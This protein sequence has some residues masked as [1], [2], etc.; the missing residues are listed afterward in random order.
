[1][2]ATVIA[3]NIGNGMLSG[4]WGLSILIEHNGKRI[5]L[6]TGASSLF[7]KNMELLGEDVAQVDY[8]V[9]SHAHYDHANGMEPFFQN[10]GKAQFYVRK[11][12]EE[13]CYTKYGIIR[14]Y[15]GM[16]RGITEK[17]SRRIVYAEG[18]VSLCEG[19]HLL[20][21]TTPE[22]DALGK[23]EHMY[24]RQG[25]RWVPDDFSHEQSLVLETAQGLLIFN[26]CSH[27]GVINTLREV[28]AAF[29]GKP[30]FGYVGGFHLFNKSPGEVRKLAQQIRETGLSVI[31]TGHCTGQRAFDILKEELGESLH[32]LAAGAVI[33]I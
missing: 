18:C 28:E 22:L 32:Q 25:R 10:N 16:P 4:E 7:L 2:K 12:A 8:A 23:R 21:H 3:D 20:H 5:L 29:P 30:V 11:G 19:A 27:G 1:M 33:D 31:W 6:D 26:C 15:I 24:R 13:N 14:K 17:F 9:L